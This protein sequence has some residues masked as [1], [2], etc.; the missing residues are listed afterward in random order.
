MKLE[1]NYIPLAEIIPY[2]KN[3][4][5]ND[6]AVEIVAKSIK[7]FSFMNPIILDKDNVIIAGHTRLKAAQLLNLQEVPVIWAEDLTEEQVK[8]FRIM[9]N[10]SQE[11]TGWDFELLK[12]E[13]N[14][15]KDLKFD[16]DLTG[17]KLGEI[18]NLDKVHS[19]DKAWVGMPEFEKRDDIY[20]IIIQFKTR[21]DRED[22][23]KKYK[24]D[25]TKKQ[26]FAWSMWYPKYE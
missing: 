6:K 21:E 3:P 5:K 14:E 2:E 10:R 18:N 20:K 17:F 4:R 9:D 15:L 7:E 16:L 22:F 23:D 8:A 12:S 1:I 26:E 25:I 13:L 24:F 11:Y 19:E